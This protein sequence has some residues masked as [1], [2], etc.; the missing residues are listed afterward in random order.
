MASGKSRKIVKSRKKVVMGFP[1]GRCRCLPLGDDAEHGAAIELETAAADR[2]DAYVAELEM[3][4]F[5]GS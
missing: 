2:I 4:G 1:E 5:R 3:H